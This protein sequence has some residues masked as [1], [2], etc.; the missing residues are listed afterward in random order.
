[1]KEKVAQGLELNE[2]QKIMKECITPAGDLVKGAK[3]LLEQQLGHIAYHLAT[4][5]L[6]E[7]GKATLIGMQTVP[8]R[9][10]GSRSTLEKAGDDHEG[11]IIGN[12]SDIIRKWKDI[13]TSSDADKLDHMTKAQTAG[14]QHGEAHS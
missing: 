5:A 6:E 4:F 8:F 7:I 3:F 12:T 1:M 14:G 11:C 10:N 13:Q 9:Q 2:S